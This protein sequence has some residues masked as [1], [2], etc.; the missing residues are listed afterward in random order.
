MVG[1]PLPP[2]PDCGGDLVWYEAGY[3]PG[4]RKCMGKPTTTAHILAMAG[5][6]LLFDVEAEH[7]Q[8]VLRRSKFS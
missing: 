8:V 1:V 4:T 6:D 3:T 7:G 5:A 2:C